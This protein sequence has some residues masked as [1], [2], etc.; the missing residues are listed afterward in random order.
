MIETGTA[1]S[2]MSVV[3][4]LPRNRNTTMPTSTK[5][6]PKRAHD[7]IDRRVDEDRGVE[8]NRVG[9]IVREALGELVHRLL[10]RLRHLDRIGS[11][12]LIDADRCAR[13]S[14]EPREPVGGFGA[15]LDARHILD[16]HD[17]AAG[18]RAQDDV[19][20]FLRLREPAL[21]LD[22]ELKLLIVGDRRGAD[23]AERGLDVLA[24]HRGDDVVR[25]E[26]ERR[27]PIRVEPNAQG[28]IERPEQARLADAIDPR[29]GVDDVDRRV[30]GEVERVVAALRRIDL[31]H[32]EKRG[33]FLANARALDASPRPGAAAQRALRDFER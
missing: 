1:I 15:D 12:R 11:R 26:I 24:L 21:R 25:R 4:N 30:I 27:H 2:G 29:Q 17:R 3:R 22:G 16:A 9:E 7:L 20:E 14:V 23:P 13:R 19:R 33:R 18:V 6:S 10:D 31:Q 8:E 28:I 32:L 5:A